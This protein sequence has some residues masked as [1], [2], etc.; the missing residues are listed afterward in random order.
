MDCALSVAQPPLRSSLRVPCAVRT[1]RA[2]PL[3]FHAPPPFPPSPCRCRRPSCTSCQRSPPLSGAIAARAGAFP[4]F[5]VS[6]ERLSNACRVSPAPPQRSPSLRGTSPLPFSCIAPCL[7]GAVSLFR[8]SASLRHCPRVQR[9]FLRALPGAPAARRIPPFLASIVRERI[10]PIRAPETGARMEGGEGTRVDAEQA[11]SGGAASPR[12]S[13]KKRSRGRASARW[14]VRVKTEGNGEGKR[15][16]RGDEA[17][18]EREGE[19]KGHRK[20]SRRHSEDGA[21]KKLAPGALKAWRRRVFP[22]VQCC[23]DARRS[24][25]DLGRHGSGAFPPRPPRAR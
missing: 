16:V 8:S 18:G 17:A 9:R 25:S 19:S 23:R 21:Q 14:R 24:F 3:R 4:A 6:P 10:R 13:G 12:A 15:C 2:V 1:R 11:G 7:R 5:V 22:F 20:G